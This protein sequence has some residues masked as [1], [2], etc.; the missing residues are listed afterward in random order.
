ME[1]EQVKLAARTGGIATLLGSICMISGAAIWGASG[2]DIDQALYDNDLAGYLSKALGSQDL[3]IANLSLW[4]LGVLLLGAGATM[5]ALLSQDRP[6]WAQLVKYNYGVGVALVVVAYMAW[7]AVVVRSAAS[8]S[9]EA[10]AIAETVGWFATRADWV[11]T[12]LMLATGPL[13]LSTAGRG[14]W[15]PN[16]LRIWS[17]LCLFTGLLNLIAQY[18]GGLTTYGFIIIPVGMGWLF[19]ASSVLLRAKFV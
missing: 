16:W 19:A 3:L 6:V 10:P 18:A 2:V 1:K 15:A 17:Y 8:A 5:M 9:A 7:L 4:I 12:V 14:R 13:L 11:A